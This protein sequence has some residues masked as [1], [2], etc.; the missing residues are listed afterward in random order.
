MNRAELIQKI[1][2]EISRLRALIRLLEQ[3]DTAYFPETE[4]EEAQGRLQALRR[5]L[6]EIRNA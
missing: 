2:D 3:A 6:E 1:Q 4:L 5:R